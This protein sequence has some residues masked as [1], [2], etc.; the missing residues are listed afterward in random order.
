MSS[1]ALHQYYKPDLMFGDCKSTVAV[2]CT[3]EENLYAIL[4]II[5]NNVFANS[6]LNA[7][8]GDNKC[9]INGTYLLRIVQRLVLKGFIRNLGKTIM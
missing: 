2:I 3:Q 9:I 1:C 6:Q 7:R 8:K 5:E 4:Y